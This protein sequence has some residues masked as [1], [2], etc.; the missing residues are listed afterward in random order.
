MSSPL[1][2]ATAS[3]EQRDILTVSA[4]N[5]KARQV[6][7]LGLG[8]VWVEAEIS[9]F[10]RAASGHWYFSL[11]DDK[12]QVRAAMFKHQ[13]GQ[14]TFTP[15]NG[16]QVLVRAEVSL[17]EERGDYQLIVS[18][19]EEA[20]HGAL[21]RAFE[22][23]RLKLSQEGLFES[24]HKKSLPRFPHAIGVITSPHGAAIRDILTTLK[25]RYPMAAIIIYPCLV[26]GVEAP[27]Q[28]VKALTLA[29]VRQ[30]CEVLIIGRG[31]GSLEDLWAFNDEKVV[32]TVF[33]MTIP[34]VSGVGH[35]IDF[36]LCDFV[37]DLRAPTPTAAAEYC[38]P[39]QYELLQYL[40][41]HR[42]RLQN[43]AIHILQMAHQH[44]LWQKKRLTEP[45][46]LLRQYQQQLD[47]VQYRLYQ[48]LPQ[49]LQKQLDALNILRHKL[50]QHAPLHKLLQWQQQKEKLGARLQSALIAQL[51]D[52]QKKLIAQSQA[53][54]T[55][56]PLATLDRGYA[57]VLK[58]QHVITDAT[59]LALGDKI[60]VK[61]ARGEVHCE[62]RS[63]E[64]N[65]KCEVPT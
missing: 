38:S 40:E 16:L 42:Q 65:S 19:M 14:T 63:N 22:A 35:E 27:E 1:A 23:L 41:K 8:R 12:A 7:S 48:A 54:H 20:G 55:I 30:E 21:Q 39:D 28:I 10:M 17:Y 13:N 25:R 44:L 24:H 6:L 49:L 26:Q 62:V 53:L 64:C 33:A 61:L 3:I 15:K 29:E 56:S 59:Q 52:K 11:K 45:R 36:S 2:T 32:R 18:Y 57:L 31:G 58:D 60:K 37:A 34:I 43:A 51:N 46:N 5:A 9:N 50:H 4:L 47:H